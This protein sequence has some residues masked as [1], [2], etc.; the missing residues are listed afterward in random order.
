MNRLQV[1]WT[2]AKEEVPKVVAITCAKMVCAQLNALR[3]IT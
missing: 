3:V 2:A 1:E